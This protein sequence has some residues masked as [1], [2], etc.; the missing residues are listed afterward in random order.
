M[1]LF[2]GYF[3]KSTLYIDYIRHTE[4]GPALIE[5]GAT[6]DENPIFSTNISELLLSLFEI[7]TGW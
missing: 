4:D 3:C 2:V 5:P 7:S 6:V 1:P